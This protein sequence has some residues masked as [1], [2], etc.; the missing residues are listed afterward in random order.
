MSGRGSSFG[1]SFESEYSSSDE[2]GDK[3]W[4]PGDGVCP[5]TSQFIACYRASHEIWSHA[6]S[7]HLE[8][9]KSIHFYLEAFLNLL[10][11]VPPFF[12][13]PPKDFNLTGHRK[14]PLILRFSFELETV[15]NMNC[16]ERWKTFDYLQCLGFP[17]PMVYK[18]SIEAQ[19]PED[20]P[21]A[22]RLL[23][24]DW[25]GYVLFAMDVAGNGEGTREAVPQQELVLMVTSLDMPSPIFAPPTMISRPA[26]AS[27]RKDSIFHELF[28]SLDKC[29]S[30]SSTREALD[31]LL[32]SAFF[33]PSVPCNLL[34]AA[35]LGIKNAL[36]SPDGV[37]N[38]RLLHGIASKTPHLSF[39]WAAAVY[40]NQA[41]SMLRECFK[42]LPP[43]CLPAAFWTNTL[44][45]FLQ[46]VYLLDTSTGSTISRAEEF[47]IS[48]FCRPA[49]SVPWSPSPPF[50]STIIQN[51]SL[52]VE[53][54]LEHGHRPRSWRIYWVLHSAERIPAS[55][56]HQVD[57]LQ[58]RIA[59]YPDI[60]E[61]S[62]EYVSEHV[63]NMY[64]DV[65]SPSLNER[66]L[67]DAQSRGATS[68]LFNWHRAY[69]DG[70]WFDD[71]IENIEAI[72]RVQLRPWIVD[73]FNKD[74]VKDNGPV[75]ESQQ[76]EV[77][78]ETILEWNAE[79]EKYQQS[80]EISVP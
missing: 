27:V 62:T 71:G 70:F 19:L 25:K 66:A 14:Y 9:P 8:D 76:S 60:G 55:E 24:L 75:K 78:R 38:Q 48:H 63:V 18:T 4:Y 7:T 72:R 17:S 68:R 50:G 33:D 13:N 3:G 40:T 79:V 47:Q 36:L 21:S 61:V 26:V 10:S 37:G 59:P 44:Q 43:L 12:H 31:S 49:P 2:E 22:S 6:A 30:L 73:P 42:M 34:G 52:E 23:V 77:D 65:S 74:M 57:V 5:P 32:R 67:A 1:D 54:H 46:V 16:D 41:E 45:S 35:S 15:G 11:N 29:M 80:A 51:L 53:E 64:T 58:C 20:I 69:D 28:N 56:R 39:L